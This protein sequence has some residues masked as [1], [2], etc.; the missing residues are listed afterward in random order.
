MSPTRPTFAW[1]PP[2][3]DPTLRV[4]PPGCPAILHYGMPGFVRE[5]AGPAPARVE[6]DPV[7]RLASVSRIW[8]NPITGRRYVQEV[9]RLSDCMRFRASNFDREI[10]EKIRSRISGGDGPRDIAP[11]SIFYSLIAGVDRIVSVSVWHAAYR[12]AMQETGNDI[13]ES[14]VRAES[15]VRTT[16]SSGRVVDLSPFQRGEELKKMIIVFYGHFNVILNQLTRSHHNLRQQ[17]IANLPR[18]AR[19]AT[20][21]SRP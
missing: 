4:A 20:A 13:E 10:A 16:Q 19:R 15:I 6:V 7:R 14:I 1:T 2:K 17:G 5:I 18:F 11:L 8:L 12:K 9:L 21:R 3:L